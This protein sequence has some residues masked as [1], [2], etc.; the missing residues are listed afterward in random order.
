MDEIPWDARERIG[1]ATAF[2]ETTRR[3]LTEPTSFFRAMPVSGGLPSPLLYG[4]VVGW[5]GLVAA[6]FYQA[7]WGS[8]VGTGWMPFGPERAEF[9][10]L[11][12]WVEGWAGFIAQVAF[13]GVFVVIGVFF[14]AGILHLM[15]LLLGG[16]RRGFEATFRVVCFSQAASLLLLVPFC[17]QLVGAVWCL[18]LYVI[19]LAQAH[20]IGHGK[21]L[22]AVLLPIAVLCCCCA[23]L[24]F[25]F[26]GALAGL[27]GQIQ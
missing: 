16:A 15:L 23:G 3:V 1:L 17:G 6:A 11:I 19:G 20:Q 7:V 21:A 26:A 24:V 2:V 12:G 27:I 18:V 22:A 13:G 4:V 10:E 5:I 25:T 8:I 9:A 14:G